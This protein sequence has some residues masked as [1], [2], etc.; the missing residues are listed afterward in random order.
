[1]LNALRNVVLGP[2]RFDAA[3]RE[4]IDRW[5]F[6]H[7]TPWDFF[8]TIEN[9]SGEDLAWFW[10]GW[11][12]NNWKLD[13]A[14]KEVNYIEKN[15][16]NGAAITI[17]NLEQMAMPVTVLIKE[18]NGKE[19]R[20]TLPVEVWQR[21]GQWTFHVNTTS[22]VTDITLDPDKQLPDF[23]RENNHYKKGF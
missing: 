2:E 11:V 14:V 12:M 6:K 15:P 1:M 5:A 8:H 3:F 22:E 23:N 4:Y 9:V 21:G 7:P 13:Q 17:Q 16:A 20:L 10:R 18:A 19:Q